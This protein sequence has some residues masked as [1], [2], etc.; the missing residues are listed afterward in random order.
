[1][2]LRTSILKAKKRIH[3][4]LFQCHFWIAWPI[5]Y[6][7]SYAGCVKNEIEHRFDWVGFEAKNKLASL[8]PFDIFFLKK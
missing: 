7:P 8:H 3:E 5:A 6:L 4:K 1:M 2:P